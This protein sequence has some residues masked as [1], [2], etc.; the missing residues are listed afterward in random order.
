MSRA[1][2][3]LAAGS[4]NAGPHT[5]GELERRLLD[6]FPASDAE[7]WDRTGML[8]GDASAQLQA[9]AVAL[10]P[11]VDALR[12][13]HALGANAL[14]CHHPLFLDPPT[15][16][17]PPSQKGNA[18]GSRVWEAIR[19]GI[20]VLS[21]HTA[22]DVSP[23]AAQVLPGKLGLRLEGILEPTAHD[24]VRGYGQ[25]CTPEGSEA[26]TLE[27]L[28]F[29]CGHVFLH[30]VRVWGEPARLLR[31]IVCCTGAAGDDLDLACDAGIDCVVAGEVRYH[32]TLDAC[33]RGLSVIE[34]GHDI[35]E[36]PLTEVLVSSLKEIGIDSRSIRVLERADNWR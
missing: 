20:S 29:R 23:R 2:G 25:I 11:T 9:V 31:R 34:L 19:L 4:R 22:L 33:S 13:A 27:G 21:F 36:Y 18:V 16:F 30:P 17:A 10:D 32:K 12:Q 28:A 7:D 3:A 15:S 26:L 5:I 14:V 8:V 6:L 24:P 35:S 1:E